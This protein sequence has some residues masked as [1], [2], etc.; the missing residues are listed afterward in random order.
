MDIFVAISVVVD[1]KR[2]KSEDNV[3]EAVKRDYDKKSI[4]NAKALLHVVN[5]FMI[6]CWNITINRRPGHIPHTHT[7]ERE[8]KGGAMRDVM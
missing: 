8:K 1:K 4:R 5:K 6:P 2:K 7:P 3:K